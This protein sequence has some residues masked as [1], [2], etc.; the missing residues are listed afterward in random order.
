MPCRSAQELQP[1]TRP[2]GAMTAS[3][4]GLVQ[5]GDDTHLLVNSGDD[6]AIV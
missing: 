4:V 3:D 2:L 5:I 1:L 6:E